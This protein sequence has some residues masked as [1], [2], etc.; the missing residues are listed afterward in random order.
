MET[1]EVSFA[2]SCFFLD[3]ESVTEYNSRILK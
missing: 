3:E 2:A 1:A